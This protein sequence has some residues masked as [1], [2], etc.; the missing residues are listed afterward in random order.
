[1]GKRII[2]FGGTFDPIHSGHIKVAEYAMTH[3]CAQIIVYVPTR[4]SPHKDCLPTASGKQRIDM[5]K[6]AIQGKRGFEV[7]DCELKRDEP[8]YTIDTVRDF[9]AKYSEKAK[10]YWLVGADAVVELAKWYQIDQ[11]V[12]EC[13]LSVMCRGG[14]DRPD[15][16]SLTDRLGLERVEKLRKN[17]IPTP[18]IRISSTE[19]RQKLARGED[20]SKMLDEKVFAYIKSKG[21]Y[22]C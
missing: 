15:F 6:L 19:I 8:S 3:V 20:V 4:R 11:L 7:S 18:L 10:L 16:S 12:D 17:V 13:E 22:G 21:L 14:L 1:M 2:L 5:V 9:R